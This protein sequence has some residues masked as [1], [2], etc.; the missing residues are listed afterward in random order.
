MSGSLDPKHVYTREAL[1]A[2]VA[3]RADAATVLTDRITDLEDR[4]RWERK[5]LL[6]P[7][8]E[9]LRAYVDEADAQSFDSPTV[10][11]A[12]AVLDGVYCVVGEL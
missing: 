5:H 9:A 6:K 8:V 12:Q 3:S 7:C 2:E 1:E 4:L 10:I 11:Q